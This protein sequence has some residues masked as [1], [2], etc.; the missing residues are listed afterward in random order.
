MSDIN[1]QVMGVV[2]VARPPNLPKNLTVCEY[3]AVLAYKK[4]KQIVFGGRKFDF[5]VAYRDVT[6]C[7]VHD[8]ILYLKY[9]SFF[10]FNGVP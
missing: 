8:Q 10:L 3:F 7:H 6:R 2:V 9:R 5:F 1:A 4:P